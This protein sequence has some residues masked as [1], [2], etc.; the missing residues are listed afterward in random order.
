MV[1]D[2]TELIINNIDVL[3]VNVS[4]VY[5]EEQLK[6]VNIK[7]LRD[8]FFNGKIRKLYDGEYEIDGVLS[9]VMVLA[10]DITL[11]DVDY[12]FNV[13]ILDNFGDE[14][15]DKSDNNLIIINNNLDISEFLWQNIVLEIPSKIVSEKNRNINLKGNGWRFVTEEELE[16]EKNNESPFDELD[17]KF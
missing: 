9:G 13:S 16:H 1:I 15:N 10:D 2:L 6:N 3:N 7:K 12:E 4:V 17:N 14:L 8:T 5:S 11:E